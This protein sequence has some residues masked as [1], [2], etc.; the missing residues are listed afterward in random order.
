MGGGGE[1]I[2]TGVAS[3]AAAGAGGVAPALTLR[4]AVAGFVSD[5]GN[6]GWVTGID[7]L[8]ARLWR[9]C[10]HSRPSNAST[11]KPAAMGCHGTSASESSATLVLAAGFGA[12]A[13]AGG[14]VGEAMAA[15]G[16]TTGSGA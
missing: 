8:V 5:G 9:R 3:G 6:D 4:S 11:A 10:R 16:Q 15:G 14:T 13:I 2:P 12:G 7:S 1:E